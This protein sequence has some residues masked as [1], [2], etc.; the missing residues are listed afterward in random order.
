MKYVGII[1]A[2]F[3][4]LTPVQ[5]KHDSDHPLS[6][7]DWKEVMDKVTSVPLTERKKA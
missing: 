7:D 2:F 5:A 6:A 1:A 4:L 3:F